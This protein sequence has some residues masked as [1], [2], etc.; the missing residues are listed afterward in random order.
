MNWAAFQILQPATGASPS[1]AIAQIRGLPESCQ[2]VQLDVNKPSA[3]ICAAQLINGVGVYDLT[4]G[5]LVPPNS[6]LRG[7]TRQWASCHTPGRA[8]SGTA[9]YT[10]DSSGRGDGAA[11]YASRS[12]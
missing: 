3:I 9:G 11:R 5:S 6:K 10:G 8:H 2:T 4:D 7:C 12:R 1:R